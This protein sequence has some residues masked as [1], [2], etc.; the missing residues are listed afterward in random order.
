MNEWI[1]TKDRLP[2]KPGD[3]LVYC[4]NWHF[5]AI[6]YFRGKTTWAKNNKYITH[7]MPLPEPPETSVCAND[8]TPAVKPMKPPEN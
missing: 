7:W 6:S 1:C 3:Y 5:V 4:C 8:V 2:D